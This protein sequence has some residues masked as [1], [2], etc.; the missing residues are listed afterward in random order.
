MFETFKCPALFVVNQAVLSLIS[1]QRTVGIVVSSGHGLTHTVPVYDTFSIPCATHA[2]AIGG[3]DLTDHLK[4]M[5]TI[6]GSVSANAADR[7][8][9]RIKEELCYVTLDIE[10]ELQC[11]A[12]PKSFTFSDGEEIIIGKEEC[13]RCPEALFQP[14]LVWQDEPGIA[15]MTYNSIMACD[16]DLQKDLFANIVLSGGSTLFHG[17]LERMQNDIAAFAPS[18]VINV[19]R[20]PHGKNAA[21]IGGSILASS[22]NFLEMCM[23]NQYYDEFGPSTVQKLFNR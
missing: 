7:E 3:N 21:W 19:I 15:E 6:N 4:R 17:V 23:S 22:S 8:I 12:P 20:H 2:L 5:L 14:S 18:S 11:S 16:V 10:K 13:V 1:S 9:S